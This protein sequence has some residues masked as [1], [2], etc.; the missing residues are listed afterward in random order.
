M[1]VISDQITW[2]AG[3]FKS[4]VDENK[5]DEPNNQNQT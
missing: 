3:C 1:L 5:V 4:G 2:H